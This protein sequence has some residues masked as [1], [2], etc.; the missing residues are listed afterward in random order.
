MRIG[1]MI[2]DNVMRGVDSELEEEVQDLP[3]GLVED[4]VSGGG[5]LGRRE[6]G[7]GSRSGGRR[8]TSGP[9]LIQIAIYEGVKTQQL[10]APFVTAAGPRAAFINLQGPQ[11]T[12]GPLGARLRASL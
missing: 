11:N 7:S 8:S 3:G 5:D 12:A 4:L 2:D 1:I 10:Q 6:L 9:T